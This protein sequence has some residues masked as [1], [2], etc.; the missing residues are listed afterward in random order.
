M[1][2][3]PGMLHGL[4][5]P[6]IGRAMLPF[7]AKA[8]VRRVRQPPGVDPTVSVVIP[9]YNY[10]RYIEQC[11]R[12]ILDQE[13][14][15][16]EVL[17]IDDASPDGSAETVRRVAASDARVSAICHKTN[18]GHIATYNEGLALATGDYTVLLS[19]DDLMTPGCLGRATALMEENPSVGLTYGSSVNF[20]ASFELPPAR[21][22]ASSWVVWNGHDWIMRLCQ[23][24]RNVLLSPEAVIRT[25]VLREIGG[26]TAALPH[27]GDLEWWLRAATVSDV[28]YIS[29]AD[30]AYY[31]QHATNMHRS[32]DL[33][34]DLTERLQAF[35]TVLD[36][37]SQLLP[38]AATMRDSVRRALAREA[39]GHALSAYANDALATGPASKLVAFAVSTWPG[40]QRSRLWRAVHRYEEMD[41]RSR[42]RS[43]S[44]A[45]REII[46]NATW[47]WRWWRRRIAGVD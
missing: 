45:R 21:A 14:V 12:S 4:A 8:R 9:C 32:Y 23:T 37:R 35:D 47:S 30:Q 3:L 25:S 5:G 7:S 17:I 20:A 34:T 22:T 39:L 33:V 31:R 10:G 46:W 36:K 42:R 28:G 43:L 38:D 19:A 6:L 44:L 40:V 41:D 29:G 16:A 2:A 27:T 1:G 24:G 11:V 26:L 18:Q 15:R 13:G